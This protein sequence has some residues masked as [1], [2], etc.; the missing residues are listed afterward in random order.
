MGRRRSCARSARGDRYAAALERLRARGLT[1]EC[2]CSRRDLAD[3]RAIPA[4]AAPAPR[5]RACRPRPGCASSRGSRS[6]PIALQGAY[7]QDVAAAVGDRDLEA[8]RRL[9]CVPARGRGR[10]CRPGRHP[11][12]ARRR[13]SGRHAAS[14]LSAARPR[15]ADPALRCTCPCW[16]NRTAPSSPSRRAA[17]RRIGPPG[18]HLAAASSSCW[19]ST[20][21][22]SCGRAGERVVG[23]G[24]G[25]LGG[26]SAF[27]A[28]RR[29][30]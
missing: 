25:S 19:L 17:C 26:K 9:L 23:V 21:P 6:S 29:C 10:R 14:D 13:P 18:L 1:F 22:A 4:I 30:N 5:R 7:R 2:S 28:P 16:W 27:R 12:G 24:A 15:A 8:P 11:R 20:R 3:E